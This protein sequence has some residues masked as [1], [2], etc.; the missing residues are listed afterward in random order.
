MG[1]AEGIVVIL[2]VLGT[3]S[4]IY[5]SR[6]RSRVMGYHDIATPRVN[7]TTHGEGGSI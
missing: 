4:L 1:V 3:A 5:I 6:S 7:E 2:L